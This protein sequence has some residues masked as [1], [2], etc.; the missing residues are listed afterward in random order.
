[1]NHDRNKESDMNTS[2]KKV[3][4]RNLLLDLHNNPASLKKPE[5]LPNLEIVRDQVVCRKYNTLSTN[6]PIESVS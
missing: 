4:D 2:G 1:M 3:Y 5:C 6:R